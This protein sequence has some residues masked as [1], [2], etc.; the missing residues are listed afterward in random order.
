[1]MKKMIEQNTTGAAG[2]L[3]VQQ[4]RSIVSPPHKP[5]FDFKYS[6][7]LIFH[8]DTA[9]VSGFLAEF[10]N[11]VRIPNYKR[12]VTLTETVLTK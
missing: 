10:H 4:M 5:H 3:S 11:S 8:N 7:Q 9:Q 1:M 12:G 2:S 6:F